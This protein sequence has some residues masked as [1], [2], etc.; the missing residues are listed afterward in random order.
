MA[1]SAE[2]AAQ[3]IL[4]L[5]SFLLIWYIFRLRGKRMIKVPELK[6]EYDG[7]ARNPHS[8]MNPDELALKEL[9]RLI[10]DDSNQ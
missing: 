1:V 5:T 6:Y 2:F 8:L 3:M 4:L 9:D 7:R 10:E